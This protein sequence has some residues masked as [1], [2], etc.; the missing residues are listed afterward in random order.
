MG[1]IEGKTWTEVLPPSTCWELLAA[2]EVGRV[3]VIVSGVPEIYPVNYVVD[4]ESIL[5]RTGTG[6]KL[7]AL[8]QSPMIAFEAD[9]VDE[10]QRLG[11]S[12]LVKGRAR[13]VTAAAELRAARELPLHLWIPAERPV[14][15]RIVPTEVTGR[16]IWSR[17]PPG[18]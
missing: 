11:W 3:S 13:E 14:W 6:S 8:T 10:N 18:T 17:T 16:R 4:G 12:V 15:I 1:V 7:D 5:F 2:T 9:S